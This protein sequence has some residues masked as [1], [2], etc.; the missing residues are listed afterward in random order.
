MEGIALIGCGNK[1]L[2]PLSKSYRSMK[3]I[4]DIASRLAWGRALYSRLRDG[5]HFFNFLLDLL[6]Y[7]SILREIRTELYIAALQE[8]RASHPSIE[9]LMSME[10]EILCSRGSYAM[11]T[12]L[13]TLGALF[14][15]SKLVSTQSF[16]RSK[17]NNSLLL[18]GV[19]PKIEKDR[20]VLLSKFYG[21]PLFVAEDGFLRSILPNAE[22]RY[23]WKWR[24]S[25]SFT[26]D[27]LAPY[28]DAIVPSRLE[29][30]INGDIELSDEELSRSKSLIHFIVENKI[31]KYNHQPIFQPKYGREGFEKVLV[32]DQR[33]GDGSIYRGRANDD[34]FAEMLQAAVSENPHAD[35]LV[36]THPDAKAGFK[37]YFSNL[38]QKGNIFPVTDPI[39]PI[40]LLLAV[41]KVYAVTSQL[42]FE[43]LM[44]GKQ[45]TLFGVP[46]YG[47]W[48]LTDDRIK[49]ERRTR[50]RTL[51]ELFALVYLK[52]TY[53]VNPTIE[54]RCEIEEALQYLL[55]ERE[56]YFETSGNSSNA[57]FLRG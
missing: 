27:D 1:S 25:V 42:G 3:R 56:R 43:A 21:A 13:R 33:Y 36:K 29:M 32:V 52:Y 19:T 18:W 11:K 46:F 40:S 44:T 26:F 7:R 28:Y 10:G 17:K 50:T 45:V 4:A 49:C 55:I 23:D 34:S 12:E 16:Y 15:S 22:V 20:L 38:R 6:R 8:Q 53:Y 47:G 57:H 39:N 35:I 2:Y 54:Q 31:S 24:I 5:F 51:E 30:V 14:P 9:E 37:G 41:D 48:G